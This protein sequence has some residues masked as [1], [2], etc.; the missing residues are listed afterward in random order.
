MSV[1][2]L[3]ELEKREEE[4]QLRR[5]SGKTSNIE[6]NERTLE[7]FRQE[8]RKKGLEPESKDYPPD[9]FVIISK[10]KE[11]DRLVD[12]TQGIKKVIGSMVR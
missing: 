4:L 3:N 8:F 11:F 10:L 7:A 5:I 2:Q 12:P 1:R 6:I 9:D